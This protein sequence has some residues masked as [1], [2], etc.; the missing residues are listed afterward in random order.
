MVY[1]GARGVTHRVV[2]PIDVDESRLHA[3]CHL[4]DDE[5]SFWLSSIL[6]AGAAPD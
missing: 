2:T 1:A 4:R 6:A 3:Y 5:R